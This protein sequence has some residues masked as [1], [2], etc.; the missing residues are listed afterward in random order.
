MQA[1]EG[2][3]AHG[4]SQAGGRLARRHGL[5]L[6]IS[7]PRKTPLFLLESR[8][9]NF[10]KGA[11]PANLQKLGQVAEWLKAH[12]WKACIRDKRIGGSNPPLSARNNSSK[13]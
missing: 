1:L 11:A 2:E 9:R 6:V 8:I 10:C 12:A 7:A 3:S 5:I 4:L 13:S